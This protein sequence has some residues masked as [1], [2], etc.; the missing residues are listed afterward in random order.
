MTRI[1]NKYVKCQSNQIGKT[2]S[3]PFKNGE[4]NQVGNSESDRV[5]NGDQRRTVD[6]YGRACVSLSM[7]LWRR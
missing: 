1:E 2:E 5:R 4:S 6:A 3:N 7:H